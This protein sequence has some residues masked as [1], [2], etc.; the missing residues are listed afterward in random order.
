MKKTIIRI[1]KKT[2]GLLN[3]FI[4][5]KNNRVYLFSIPDYTGNSK[6]MSDYLINEHPGKYELV[7]SVSK[8]SSILNNN[9]T[10]N[11]VKKGS[12]K[13][14]IYFFTSKYII[15]THNEMVSICGNNQ[16][17]ISLWHGMPFK[18]I[19]YLGKTDYIGMENYSAKR[20]ATSEITRS[21]ISASFCEKANNVYITGQPRND[22]LF[23]PYNVSNIIPSISKEKKLLLYIPTFRENRNN[24]KYSDGSCINGDNFLRV[25]D[26]NITQLNNFLDENNCILLL[27]LHPYEEE[28]FHNKN[29]LSN[30]IYILNSQLMNSAGIDINQLL[31]QCHTL[32]T[33]YSSI[34]LDFLII[35]KPIIFL[36]PDIK[37]Y[38]LSR[39]GFTL[40]PY[41]FWM[42]GYKIET[43]QD[44]LL[45]LK[46]LLDEKDEYIEK[47]RIVN[48]I[49]NKFT[50]NK[51]SERVYN[52]FFK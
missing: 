20:I 4:Y 17:Y 44:L 16:V 49:I 9:N 41:D 15:S 32:I 46:K 51:N 34:Y 42:P 25:D 26:F 43:Q 35:E 30:N 12:L 3:S 29:E 31:S 38:A 45:T 7:W 48:T 23:R 5:K 28:Y 8:P 24:K 10:I 33:D 6:A 47:R 11:M 36:V 22:L 2:I 39:G 50:D 52:E 18:K 37:E 14:Y 40:E 19:C 21:I 1:L 27:K 13:S